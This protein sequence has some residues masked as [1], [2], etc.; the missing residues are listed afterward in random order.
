[1]PAVITLDT[2]ITARQLP[3]GFVRQGDVVTS[4]GYQPGQ[5]HLELN[6]AQPVGSLAIQ[7]H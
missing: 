2:G 3:A 6:L 5:P 7:L 1:M 4:A